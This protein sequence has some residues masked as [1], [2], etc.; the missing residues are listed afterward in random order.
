VSGDI[1]IGLPGGIRVEPDIS[2][3]SGRTKLPSR[4]PAAT[5]EPRRPVRVRL[6]SVSGNITIERVDRA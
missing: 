2:T 1:A 5:T 3:L 4:P 6:R